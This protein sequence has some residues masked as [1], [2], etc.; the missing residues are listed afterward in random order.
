MERL[1]CL[2]TRYADWLKISPVYSIVGLLFSTCVYA[3]TYF[4]PADRSAWDSVSLSSLGWCE[5]K[6]D[7]LLRYVERN[8]S[9][10]FIVLK[11]GRIAIEWYADGFLRSDTWY[12]ASAGKSVTSTLVGIAERN[13]HLSLS[14]ASSDYL[15]NGWTSL[16]PEQERSITIWHQLTMTSGLDDGTGDPDCT[17]P[18]CLVF[19]ADPGS[20][21][22]YHNAPYTLLD[23]V[24]EGATDSSRNAYLSTHLNKVI[25]MDGAFL[26]LGYNQVLFSTPRSM[27]RYGLLALSDFVWDGRRILDEAFATAAVNS[28]Q[29]L[30][31]SYGYLWWLNGKASFMLPSLQAVFPGPLTSNAP[32]DAF[33]AL[34]KN[35]QV[36]CVVPSEGVV[37]IR[38]GEPASPDGPP[39]PTVFV[40]ELWALLR[41]VMCSTSSVGAKHGEEVGHHNELLHLSRIGA[42]QWRVT[43]GIG[44]FVVYDMLGQVV[45]MSPDDFID[46]ERQAC[47]SYVVVDSGSRGRGLVHR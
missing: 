8:D 2:S 29:E 45:A 11:D 42:T 9:K 20:R 31:K 22:A 23:D 34:G 6:L 17:D 30:N 18:G 43:N 7:T 21:W 12:W 39:V 47:G 35:D 27:A 40:N 19:K 3:Q 41:D 1:S 46:L 38:M 32:P 15:G 16:A 37:F 26:K 14:D 44:P 5:E 4:P 36:L 33:Y 10:A 24:L 25:G 13:G 28:S